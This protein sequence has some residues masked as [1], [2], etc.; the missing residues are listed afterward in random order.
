ML[1]ENVPLLSSP[2]LHVVLSQDVRENFQSL[3]LPDDHK[4]MIDEVM[5]KPCESCPPTQSQPQHSM[6]QPPEFLS[7]IVKG[8]S[9]QVFPAEAFRPAVTPVISSDMTQ[10]RPT[11]NTSK[12]NALPENMTQGESH[13]NNLKQS[14]FSKDMI[15][16]ELPQGMKK[17]EPSKDV[18]TQTCMI[19]PLFFYTGIAQTGNFPDNKTRTIPL[20]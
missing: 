5:N 9:K 15:K 6:P 20:L 10:T 18:R 14:G 8:T 3:H 11:M 1:S 12:Q 13:M 16:A 4:V 19:K 2:A 7:K 17:V